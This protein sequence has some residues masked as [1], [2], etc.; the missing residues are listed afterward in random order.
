MNGLL[1]SAEC[2]GIYFISFHNKVFVEIIIC[3][4]TMFIT[5]FAA[6]LVS[7][8]PAGGVYLQMSAGLQKKL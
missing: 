6:A 8:R 4:V 1:I 5:F 7:S 3:A 2:T